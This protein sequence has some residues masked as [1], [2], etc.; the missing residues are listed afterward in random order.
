MLKQKLLNP[1]LQAVFP[2]L[3]AA[4]PPG[5]QD[6]EDVEDD[7]GDGTDNENPKHCAAQVGIAV[8]IYS[9]F[10]CSVTTCVVQQLLQIHCRETNVLLLYF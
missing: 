10:I 3:T 4:P 6:P 7:S 9:L 2:I 5:E 1:I 8:F